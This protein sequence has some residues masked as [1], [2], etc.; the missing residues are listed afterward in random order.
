MLCFNKCPFI[1]FTHFMANWWSNVIAVNQHLL[2]LSRLAK[3]SVSFMVCTFTFSNII[4]PL[5]F[6]WVWRYSSWAHPG[7]VSYQAGGKQMDCKGDTFLCQKNSAN[8]LANC[9]LRRQ[10]DIVCNW[11]IKIKVFVSFPLKQGCVMLESLVT[12]LTKTPIGITDSCSYRQKTGTSVKLLV[13]TRVWCT[14][15]LKGHFVVHF[16]C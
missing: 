9:N 16:L 12:R 6:S 10:Y 2:I 3:Q 7:T 15:Q 14:V 11:K 1:V 13:R 8:Y 4:W 5:S